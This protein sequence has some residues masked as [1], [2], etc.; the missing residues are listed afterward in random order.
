[1]Q[2]EGKKFFLQPSLGAKS[3]TILAERPFEKK[4]FHNRRKAR[5][6]NHTMQLRF[7]TAPILQLRKILIP[8]NPDH[9][10]LIQATL[11]DRQGV[12]TGPTAGTD[13]QLEVSH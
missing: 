6:H 5:G 3:G 11:N 4:R 9:A 12:A 7:E 13:Q 2:I 8:S 10:K 1:M